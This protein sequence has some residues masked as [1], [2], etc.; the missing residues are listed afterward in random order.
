VNISKDTLNENQVSMIDSF[1]YRIAESLSKEGFEGASIVIMKEIAYTN[2]LKTNPGITDSMNPFEQNNVYLLKY[3]YDQKHLIS[4]V[5][6]PS[7]DKGSN[8]IKWLQ[9]FIMAVWQF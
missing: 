7:S 8:T 9:L 4:K 6:N 3:G 1:V 2:K 5:I